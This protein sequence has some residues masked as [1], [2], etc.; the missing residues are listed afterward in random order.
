MDYDQQKREFVESKRGWTVDPDG[1]I[2]CPCGRR[3]EDDGE[4]PDGH[5][6]PMRSAGII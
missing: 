4:C 1:T 2:R 6:S 3:I 5:V